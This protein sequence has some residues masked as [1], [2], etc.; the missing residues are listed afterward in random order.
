MSTW[1]PI[2][3][4]AAVQIGL[5]LI[6]VVGPIW[7]ERAHARANC[8]QIDAAAAGGVLVQESRGNE[9]TLLIIPGAS[10]QRRPPPADAASLRLSER[11][12]ER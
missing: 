9:I 11:R 1:V 5:R 4:V 7:R 3:V 2:A 6:S 10:S 8:L 12:R